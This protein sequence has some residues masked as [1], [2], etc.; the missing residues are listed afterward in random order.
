MG[1]CAP[2]FC[3]TASEQ[4]EKTTLQKK[5]LAAPKQPQP[6]LNQSSRLLGLWAPTFPMQQA[7]D[8][9]K[10]L[11]ENPA[12]QECDSN[13]SQQPALPSAYFPLDMLELIFF[14]F[15]FYN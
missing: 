5:P 2:H 9:H 13:R 7:G 8:N 11:L 3:K 6:V 4:Q 10:E 14:F 1:Q 15:F 12:S